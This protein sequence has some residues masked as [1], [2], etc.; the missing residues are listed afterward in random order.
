MDATGLRARSS[1]RKIR[2][3]TSQVGTASQSV[4]NLAITVERHFAP[5]PG[6]GVEDDRLYF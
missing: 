2:T 6:A 5:E 1:R 4:D 3:A